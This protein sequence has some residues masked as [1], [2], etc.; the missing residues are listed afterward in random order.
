MRKI[1][2]FIENEDAME[3]LEY[4]VILAVVA[5]LIAIAVSVG[6]TIKTKGTNVA[7]NL[8]N[9]AKTGN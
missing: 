5:G 7:N 6:K 2:D 9:Y 3:T 1:L 4:L 8:D